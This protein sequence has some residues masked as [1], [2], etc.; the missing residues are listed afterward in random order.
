MKIINLGVELGFG[1]HLFECFFKFVLVRTWVV[2]DS[3]KDNF[4]VVSR[5]LA[6]AKL[7]EAWN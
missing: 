1:L 6:L 5:L 7:S 2:L 4:G 3:T